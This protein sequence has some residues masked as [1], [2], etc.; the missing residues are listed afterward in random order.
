[1]GR[2]ALFLDLDGTLLNDRKEITPGNQSAIEKALSLGHLIVVTSGRPLVSTAP[3]ADALGLDRPGCFVIAC[4]GCVF[5]DN[6]KK[7][8]IFSAAIPLEVV[9][10]VFA[11]A[12]RRNIHVQAYDD[13]KV[14]VEER[15][16]G[17]NVE[18]YCRRIGMQW[19]VIP[20]ISRLKREPEKLLAIDYQDRKPLDDFRLWIA[21]NCGDVLDTYYSNANYMEI[22]KKGINKGEAILRLAS[23]LGIR[24]EDTIAA[25]DAENDSFMLRSAQ[26]GAAMANAEPGV[27]AAADYITARDNN[28]DGVAEIIEKFVLQ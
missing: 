16:A 15:C 17:K 28:H 22:V 3:L 11:E 5:Y 8:V 18:E 20:S 1:M 7:E 9:R 13:K 21:E 27:K 25:G 10:K 23:L 4:N 26:I 24:A 14:L 19:E 6:Y 12:E 2:K